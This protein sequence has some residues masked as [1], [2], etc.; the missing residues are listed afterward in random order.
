MAFEIFSKNGQILPMTEAN[1]PLSNIEY[2]YG[3]GVYENVRGVRRRPI[4][5]ADHVERLQMS[6]RAIGLQHTFTNTD[7]SVWIDALLIKVDADAVNLKVML[8]GA[9]DPKQAQ[10]I[11]LPLAPLFPD[12]KLYTLG[13]S[14]RIAHYE[15]QFPQ[16]KTLNM[17]GSYIAYS[18]AK[19]HECYDALLVDR[20]GNITEG[21]RTNFFGMRGNDIIGAL[22]GHVL[23]GVTMKHMLIAAKKA[24]FTYFERN[25]KVEDLA[26]FDCTFLTS[27][28]SKVM[29]VTKIDDVEFPIPPQLKELMAVF[30]DYLHTHA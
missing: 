29:P 2:A 17:L 30:D 4:F 9:K 11:I 16:A 24:G 20:N 3:F 1:V 13:A 28:S 25:T 23:E 27:T 15:R 14:M 21:T 8:I 26:D 12:K 10:L 22:S 6:A 19:A 18:K 5:V 7:I